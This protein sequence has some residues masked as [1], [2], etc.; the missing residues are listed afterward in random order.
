MLCS[1]LLNG[2]VQ[3]MHVMPLT[4]G[5]DFE[6]VSFSFDPHERPNLAAQK[7][8][9]YVRDYGR[10]Q[11]AEGWHFLTGSEESVRRL[12]DEIGFRYKY[13]AATGQW[14]HTSGIVLLTPSGV[15]SKYFYGIEYDP[16]DLRLGMIEASNGKVGS[17]VDSVVLYCF[18]YNPATG[19]YS[20]AIM[21]LL[22]TAAVA[23][24]LLIATYVLLNAKR[25]RWA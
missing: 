25:K 19:K 24:V 21:R 4:A 17:L 12:T 2:L 20:I 22:R 16:K 18:Q 11:A 1:M 13:D 7:K 5:K 3:A 10:Q 6:I 9:H 23:T 15:V 14:A 8:Q